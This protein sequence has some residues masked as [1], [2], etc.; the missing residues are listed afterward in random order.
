MAKRVFEATVQDN[1]TIFMARI[2]SS[3]ESNRFFARIRISNRDIRELALTLDELRSLQLAINSAIN[4][5]PFGVK[6]GYPPA[7]AIDE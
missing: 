4:Q 1:G 3:E 5:L 7:L 2:F 6:S